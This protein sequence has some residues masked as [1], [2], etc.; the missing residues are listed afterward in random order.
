MKVRRSRGRIG[1]AIAIAL[2]CFAASGPSLAEQHHRHRAHTPLPG[3]IAVGHRFSPDSVNIPGLR[4]ID[5]SH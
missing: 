4:R 1:A 3:G 2:S 5:R